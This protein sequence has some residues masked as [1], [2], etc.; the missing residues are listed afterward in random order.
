MRLTPHSCTFPFTP[1]AVVRFQTIW[2]NRCLHF[3]YL[4][5][6]MIKHLL[7]ATLTSIVCAGRLLAD[8]DRTICTRQNKSTLGKCVTQQLR[9]FDNVCASAAAML[10]SH[11]TLLSS[12]H[13]NLTPCLI[14]SVEQRCG[15]CPLVCYLSLLAAYDTSPKVAALILMTTLM[16]NP[17]ETLFLPNSP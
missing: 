16:V 11:L 13:T 1:L 17:E 9:G 12:F 14:T 5:K 7:C 8:S 15:L 6:P 2:E 4:V 10:T 3:F